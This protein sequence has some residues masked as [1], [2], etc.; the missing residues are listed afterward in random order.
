MSGLS[1]LGH[2]L[3]RDGV[4]EQIREAFNGAV[5][6]EE[7]AQSYLSGVV[8]LARAGAYD[9]ARAAV[10]DMLDV[11]DLP[12][13]PHALR[14]AAIVRRHQGQ[15]WESL[16]LLEEALGLAKVSGDRRAEALA[17]SAFGVVYGYLREWALAAR[18]L[19][20]TVSIA[21]ELGEE[22]LVRTAQGNRRVC[23][24][25][26]GQW[27]A[28]LSDGR[29]PQSSDLG[30]EAARALQ[31][32][33]HGR[34]LRHL[35]L[36]S[37]A[38]K[39]LEPLARRLQKEPL[40][41]PY[42]LTHEYLGECYLDL[43]SPRKALASLTKSLEVASQTA[44]DGEVAAEAL[45]RIGEAQFMLRRFDEAAE[46]LGK[47][48]V[49]I[50]KTRDEFERVGVVRLQAAL[51]VEAGNNEAAE[52][53]FSQAIHLCIQ[54]GFRYEHA[55]TLEYRGNAHRRIGWADTAEAFYD[56]A[57]KIFRELGIH[58]LAIRLKEGRPAIARRPAPPKDPLGAK[59]SR[60]EHFGIITRD[61]AFIRVLETS[62]RAA[63]SKDPVLIIGESGTG[64]ELIARLIHKISKRRGPIVD[65]NCPA[66]PE[67]ML[68]SELFGSRRGAYTGA[69]DRP[70][71]V[72]AAEGGTLFLDE[73]GDMPLALQVK[74]LRFLES[75]E[76][77]RVG[78]TKTRSVDTRIVSATNADLLGG[79][80]DKSFRRD[81]Y[82]RLSGLIIRIPP[83][84]ARGDDLDYLADRFLHDL[85]TGTGTVPSFDPAAQYAIRSYPWPG[86]VRELRHAITHA[87]FSLADRK[88]ITA[89]M[90]PD[91]IGSFS[92][93]DIVRRMTGAEILDEIRRY[94]G[95]VK[96]MASAM[97][98]S[99]QTVYRRLTE[100]EIDIKQAVRGETPPDQTYDA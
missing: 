1:N 48:L 28:I 80:D 24:S 18:A 23:M 57:Q 34:V 45:R 83:L 38:R 29:W 19:E 77:R 95:N 74:L 33:N 96:E 56:E 97:G 30:D 36:A 27:R 5:D 91:P 55:V 37:S 3:T 71:L 26:Q 72:A 86:N 9:T 49:L 52:D 59:A 84:R 54:G 67:S 51:E 87:L 10:E 70:G 21:T 75:S 61:L 46:P 92:P 58:R 65:I 25:I 62:E 41:R 22:G 43:L 85:Y 73:I 68:E 63:H 53:L 42:A 76:Y 4:P 94:D 88:R 6:S 39:V 8:A 14:V 16:D 69:E 82:H 20:K 47:A 40:A 79:V 81:L 17:Y 78:E 11:P 89:D 60:W 99:R 100:L 32:A 66:I 44:P 15:A 98:V 93:R 13:R 90:L 31:Q 2:H 35:G 64:K 50:K 7:R 12:N